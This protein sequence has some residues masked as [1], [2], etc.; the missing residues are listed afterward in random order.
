MFRTILGPSRRRR[1]RPPLLRT[2]LQLELLES[3][4]VL[5]DLHLT[6]LVQ[7]S[8]TSPFFGNPIEANDPSF[9]VNSEVEP[10]VAVD[11]T[12][13]Q[14]LVG[15]W[16]QDFSRGIVAAVSFNGGNTWQ[17][18]VVPGVSLCSGGIYP[19]AFDPWVSVAPN[20]DVYLS[21]GGVDFQPHKTPN[22]ILVSKSTD[23]GLSWGAPTALITDDSAFNDKPSITADPT[24]PQFAYATWALEE[25]NRTV[26]M[27]SRTTD[28]GQTWEPARVTFDP[29]PKNTSSVNQIVV[30]PDGTLVNFLFLA[31]F[32]NSAG[33]PNHYDFK[34]SLIRS[35]DKGVT[36][37]P[38]NTLIPVADVLPLTDADPAVRTIP[39]PDG[40]LGIR[41]PEGAV[42][43]A[44]D[45]ANGNLY[46]VWQDARFSNFQYT[47]IAFSMSTD[48]GFTW[49][50]PIKIN[51]TPSNIPLGNQQAFLPS[52]AVNQ[53]GVVAITYYDLRNN[54]PDPGLP[55]DLWMVH[56]HPADGLTN[57]AGWSSENRLT[58]ASFDMQEIGRAS[59]R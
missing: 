4:C 5:S 37:T 52:V 35:A 57:P 41:A 15:A 3:R 45:P 7:V 12:N 58:K 51:Q 14:H 46:S 11:P 38:A 22:A 56:S 23:G 13:S 33:G 43:F 54:T 29:G 42:S 59:C 21:Q 8:D 48:G 20:G 36:W 24:N 16:T 31:E 32:K 27:F 19:Y 40:G 2:Q 53:N 10:Y 25:T 49:S 6:P 1:H 9:A 17:S 26:S 39:N 18:V 50:A 28:G 44:V 34:L 30:L 55:T 47:S